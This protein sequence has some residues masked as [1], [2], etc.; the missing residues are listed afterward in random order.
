MDE[1]EPLDTLELTL[2]RFI[3]S[4]GK[5]GFRVITPAIYNAVEVLGLL[6]A[7]K[8]VIHREMGERQ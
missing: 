7:A 8:F 4:D 3:N 1:S 5:L 6:E 2:V